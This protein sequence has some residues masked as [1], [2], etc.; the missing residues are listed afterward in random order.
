MGTK[1]RKIRKIDSEV[2]NLGVISL[3]ASH[4][5]LV[6]SLSGMFEYNHYRSL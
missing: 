2:N 1:F 4:M 3:P 6:A 5:L